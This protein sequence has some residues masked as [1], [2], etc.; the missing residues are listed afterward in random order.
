MKTKF[1]ILKYIFNPIDDDQSNEKQDLQLAIALNPSIDRILFAMEEYGKQQYNQAI[2]D[3]SENAET[4]YP[5]YLDGN[6]TVNE[7]SVNK[8]SILK[9]KKSVSSSV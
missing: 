2:V 1:E 3:A 6:N 7:V 4:T 8:D 9:L 5:E